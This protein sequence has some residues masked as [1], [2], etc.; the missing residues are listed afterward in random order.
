MS[1]EPPS[2]NELEGSKDGR[3]WTSAEVFAFIGFLNTERNE[4]ALR[5]TTAKFMAPILKKASNFMSETFP[6]RS[7]RYDTTLR[8]QFR[9]IRDDYRIFK[10][11]SDASGTEWNEADKCFTVSDIQ[12]AGF[13]EKYDTRAG[14]I[15]DTGLLTNDF[16]TIDTYANIFSDEP[17]AGRQILPARVIRNPLG[18]SEIPFDAD[19]GRSS[20]LDEQRR[21]D[22]DSIESTAGSRNSTAPTPGPSRVAK[23]T[24]GRKNTKAKA[25]KT[26]GTEANA[27]ANARLRD[28][29]SQT[30]MLALRDA[31]RDEHGFSPSL[32]TAILLWIQEDQRNARFWT[33]IK[34]TKAKLRCLRMK[35]GFED[36]EFPD[37]LDC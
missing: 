32:T 9:R 30:H 17:D 18:A 7:W 11:I 4:G 27:I 29:E 12:R 10:N 3:Q 19:D 15:I 26:S 13:I 1:V 35:P 23:A 33:S 14:R 28:P 22:L 8:S 37:D 31:A 25:P 36:V 24:T 16:I 21:I 20:D 34:S 5:N 6:Q 2:N